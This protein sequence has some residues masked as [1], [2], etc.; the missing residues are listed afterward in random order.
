MGSIISPIIPIITISME[1]TIENT[2]LSMKN[3]GFISIFL[4][5]WVNDNTFDFIAFY[6]LNLI[7]F[8]CS[9]LLWDE[10]L[11]LGIIYDILP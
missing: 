11:F 8:F 10:L 9:Q 5:R 2:G 7:Y 4:F 3:P 1:R 6:P